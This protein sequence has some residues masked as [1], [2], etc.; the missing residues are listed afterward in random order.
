MRARIRVR[1]TVGVRVSTVPSESAAERIRP[2]AARQNRDAGAVGVA[3]RPPKVDA[4][5]QGGQLHLAH[6]RGALQVPQLHRVPRT[7][8]EQAL[9]REHLHSVHL[10]LRGG[11]ERRN[12]V[13]VVRRVDDDLALGAAG[14][15]V[16]SVGVPAHAH[17][18][19]ARKRHLPAHRTAD[20]P[21]VSAGLAHRRDARRVRRRPAKV[22]DP[23]LV[24][25]ERAVLPQAHTHRH[26]RRT[27]AVTPARSGGARAEAKT[28]VNG[29]VL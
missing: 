18:L 7:R 6:L 15:H 19:G 27:T 28:G 24:P 1:V 2:L 9:A 14:E 12:G 10:V 4:A 11:I 3:V 26:R 17:Q 25:F 16:L 13:A 21:D 8:G 5:S 23:A 22:E 20:V 29:D